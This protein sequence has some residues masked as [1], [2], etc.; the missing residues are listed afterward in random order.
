MDYHRLLCNQLTTLN[1]LLLLAKC[2]CS[3]FSRSA[4]LTGRGY[5][6]CE[7]AGN[8]IF[9]VVANL[10]QDVYGTENMKHVKFGS[11]AIWNVFLCILERI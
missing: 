3:G 6:V 4:E 1:L 10:Q 7:G 8:Q 2:L 5:R 11:E 9:R